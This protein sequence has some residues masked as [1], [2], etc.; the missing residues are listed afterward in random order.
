MSAIKKAMGA[1]ALLLGGSVVGGGAGF[2][3]T[4]LLG[5]PAG[6]AA[7]KA[8]EKAAP[9]ATTFVE[10]DEVV[11]PLVLPDGERL[12]GY[13]SFQLALEVPEEQAEIVTG[14]LPVL[15]HEINMRAY[16]KPMASGPDGTLPTLEIFRKVVIEAA[17]VAFGKGAVKSVAI[18]RVNPA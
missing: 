5:P 4:A 12:A 11:A 18:S 8:A 3:T 6:T 16:L 17:D 9:I 10:V 2:A 14:R 13:V 1:I 7:D 15:R